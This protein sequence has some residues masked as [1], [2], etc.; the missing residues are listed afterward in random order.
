MGVDVGA[1]ETRKCDTQGGPPNYRALLSA[2][3]RGTAPLLGNERC[4]A[5]IQVPRRKLGQS[6]G[7]AVGVLDGRRAGCAFARIGHRLRL[8]HH[9]AGAG[10]GLLADVGVARLADGCAR[11]DT[12]IYIRGVNDARLSRREWMFLPRPRC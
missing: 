7:D 5:D 3:A 10:G 4:D 1:D 12:H 11:S 8:G 9:R 6:A 2:G